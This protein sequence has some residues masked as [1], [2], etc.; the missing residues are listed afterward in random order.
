MLREAVKLAIEEREQLVHR[1]P[2]G[3]VGPPNQCV[4]VGMQI[5]SV[6]A[7]VAAAFRRWGV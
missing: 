3:L 4:D 7:F 2:V 6:G 1:G 5:A